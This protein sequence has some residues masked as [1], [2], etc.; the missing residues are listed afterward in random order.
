MF[1]H[2]DDKRLEEIQKALAGYDS[3]ITQANT[4]PATG[5]SPDATGS[6]TTKSDTVIQG[7]T[8]QDAT[9]LQPTEQDV[10]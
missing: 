6:A 1:T 7:T 9:Q 3:A 2:G 10:A 8:T 5:A 4:T